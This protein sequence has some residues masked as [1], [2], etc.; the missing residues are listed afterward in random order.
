MSSTAIKREYPYT[1]VDE[2]DDLEGRSAPSR[3]VR[4]LQDRLKQDPRFNPPTPSPWKRAGLVL[5][6]VVLF[7]LAFTLRAQLGRPPK[8][9]H[10]NRCVV[11]SACLRDAEMLW[12]GTRRSTSTG[13]L[14][15][16]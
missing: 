1:A 13:R 4:M 14:R 16:R 8:V 3:D 9:V 2:D 5:A 11:A 12:A 7:W 15:A 10:A 6:V